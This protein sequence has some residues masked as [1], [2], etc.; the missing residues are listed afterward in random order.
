MTHGKKA[1]ICYIIRVPFPLN[2]YIL[3]CYLISQRMIIILA[4]D[5]NSNYEEQDL[6]V[7]ILQNGSRDFG[8]LC[9]GFSITYCAIS[10]Y[11]MIVIK[12]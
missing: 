9:Q 12:E 4:T 5:T 8:S 7:H 10:V 3:H 2:S 11:Y 1:Y 6:Y